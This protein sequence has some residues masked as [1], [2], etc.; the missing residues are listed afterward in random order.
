MFDAE[1]TAVWLS[2]FTALA[3]VTGIAA[4]IYLVDRAG[5]R[6]LI[7]ISLGLV[8]IC[9][10]G[11]GGSFYLSRVSSRSVLST[12]GECHGI[13][14]LVWSGITTYC[15]DCAQMQECGFCGGRCVAGD[16]KGPFQRHNS[17][18]AFDQQVCARDTQWIYKS[19][20]NPWGWLSVFFMVA[21]LMAFG[22]GMGGLPWTINS[23][24]F[25]SRYR[26]MAVSCSTASN[27]IG[28]LIVSSTFLS[29]SRP[30]SMTA[31]GAF[32][33]YGCVAVIGFVW[34]FFTL[35][36]T[37]GLSLEEIEQMFRGNLRRHGRGGG[38][39]VIGNADDDESSYNDGTDVI[40][41]DSNQISRIS[42]PELLEIALE[43]A[44][45]SNGQNPHEPLV[46]ET[47]H[48]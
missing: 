28:N 12:D 40:S 11:L 26:S 18:G 33:M 45:S 16:E 2:G 13:K 3:Q 35:P 39:D 41:L 30:E 43:K 31:Y 48:R 36:E 46:L 38:Y 42:L 20:S 29:I 21:Y 34:L 27:W 4:S 6:Q 44:R 19:C 22:I 1:N 9:L 24:I 10:L 32:W 47:Y 14:A 5:R 25:P 7:L 37:K 17:T 23:E 8:S 15:Y